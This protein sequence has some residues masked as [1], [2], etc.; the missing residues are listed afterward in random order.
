[1][2]DLLIRILIEQALTL[3][4]DDRLL[5]ELRALT[6]HCTEL[7]PFVL[8]WPHRETNLSVTRQ[9]AHFTGPSA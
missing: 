3:I 8:S 2:A 1:M 7:V 6:T 5:F 4:D 9:H